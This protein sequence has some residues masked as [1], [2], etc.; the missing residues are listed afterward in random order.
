MRHIARIAIVAGSLVVAACTTDSPTSPLNPAPGLRQ[1][2]SDGTAFY[3]LQTSGGAFEPGFDAAVREARGTLDRRHSEIGVA[4]VSSSAADFATKAA[5]I[6]GITSVTKDFTVQWTHPPATLIE[7]EADALDPGSTAAGGS[8]ETFYN[9]QWAVRAIDADDALAAGQIGTG[10]RVAIIDGGIQGAHLDLSGQ[11]DVA[12]SVSFVPGFAWNQDVGSF[13]HGTHVAGIVAA[14]D[15]GVGTIGIAPGA[16]LIGV[17]VL[18]GG[19]G[20][21][22]AVISGIM[23]ASTP[24]AEGGGGADIIN[25]SLGATFLRT[26]NDG[27]AELLDA[28]N[29]ATTYAK[30][31]GVTTIAAAGN[32]GL[33]FD[34]TPYLVSVPAQSSFVIAIAA[35]G[36]VGFAL[37]A[38]NFSRPASYTN[39][40]QSLVDLAGPGGDFVL[41]GS[42]IC[43]IPVIPAGSVVAPCWVFDMVVSPSGG[44]TGSYAF[45]AGT[46]MAAPAASGVAALIVGKFGSISAPRIEAKLRQSST[47]L[48]EPGHDAFYGS[49]WVNALKAVQ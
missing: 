40:G 23:Y 39:F 12:R 26:R 43:S 20:T 14:S 33:D 42:A 38:T 32:E 5:K 28:L 41:P 21:F 9:L 6:S 46:S 17:K 37:G 16:T 29:R 49:G 15:N 22:G 31:Q 30:Q 27:T 34:N 45:A 44:G 2:T 24:I 1:S 19:G 13:W 3:V 35:T 11:I 10:A 8:D 7:M 47:D 36:P 25:M 18:H 4:I 48:G